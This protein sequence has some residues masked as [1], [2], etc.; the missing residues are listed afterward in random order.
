MKKQTKLIGIIFA[1]LGLF[2]GYLYWDTCVKFDINNFD[3]CYIC[4][5]KQINENESIVI[6]IYCQLPDKGYIN[7]NERIDAVKK[8]VEEYGGLPQKYSN[9][10]WCS[11]DTLVQYYIITWVNADQ[12]QSEE[13]TSN[14]FVRLIAN[15]PVPADAY[16]DHVPEVVWINNT[17]LTIDDY[18]ISID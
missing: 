5:E 16:I 10:L 14:H 7:H 17:L 18:K 3:L 4:E 2:F 1:G 6:G 8:H 13:N 9:L 15:I 11:S 12:Q